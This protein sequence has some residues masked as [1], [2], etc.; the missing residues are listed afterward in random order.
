MFIGISC[1][2]NISFLGCDKMLEKYIDGQP[3]LY[4]LTKN[5]IKNNKISHA[6]LFEK[7]NNEDAPDIIF[8]FVKTLL[9]PKK[10]LKCDSDDCKVCQRIDEGNYP[11]IKIINPDGM[12]IKKDQMIDL[13]KEF[14]TKKI[15]G[16]YRIYI[17]NDCE[18]FNK[19]A[20]NSILKFLEEPEEDIIAI[21][22]TNNINL[23]IE[24]IISRCQVISLLPKKDSLETYDEKIMDNVINFINHLEKDNKNAIIYIKDLWH[25]KFKDKN[26]YV[27]AFKYIICIYKACV[28]V[29]NNFKIKSNLVNYSK[30]IEEVA[31]TNTMDKLLE[32]MAVFIKYNDMIRYNLNVN[33]LID[34][35]VIEVGEI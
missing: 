2:K 28:D 27:I 20:S 29:K 7:N 9:C 25:N 35:I 26:D 31:L 14:S 16:L 13:Q 30:I 4:K 21:L 19:Y 18:K 3:I 6:Y 17:I 22:V 11:E 12:W 32:K 23:I 10:A 5:I 8:S 1:F 24:T 15:E 33:I 34:K